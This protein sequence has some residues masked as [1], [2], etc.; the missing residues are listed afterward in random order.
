MA[1]TRIIADGVANTAITSLGTLSTLTVDNVNINGNSIVATSGALNITPA[2]GSALVLDGTVNVD[3]GVITGATSVTSTAFVGAL[4]GNVTGNAS[5]TA[6]TVTTAAQPAITSVGTLTSFR[7]TGID[8]NSNALAMTIDSSERVGIGTASP[9]EILHIVDGGGSDAEI[10]LETSTDSTGSRIHLK[11][12][13]QVGSRYHT[14]SSEYGSTANWRIGGTGT[15]NAIDFA[16]GSGYTNIM[17]INDTGVGIGTTSP[18][19]KLHTVS[20]GLHPGTPRY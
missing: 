13:N 1:I 3:A 5:G 12:S 7:S 9:S 17:R 14:I 20:T 19:T 6:A 18:S 16:I 8:D 4:T 15:D 11:S 2:A 10:I